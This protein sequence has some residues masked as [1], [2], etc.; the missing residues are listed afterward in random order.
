MSAVRSVLL[1]WDWNRVARVVVSGLAVFLALRLT[2]GFVTGLGAT[3]LF[4]AV[5]TV[6]WEIADRLLD[7]S[8][9]S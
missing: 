2:D 6:P 1:E 5:F 7:R 9:D 8:H 3:F 4:L